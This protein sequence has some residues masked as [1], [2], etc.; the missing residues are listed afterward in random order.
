[1][2]QVFLGVPGRSVEGV[3]PSVVVQV[4]GQQPGHQ[5]L[6]LPWGLSSEATRNK[7]RQTPMNSRLVI[8]I[9]TT[10]YAYKKSPQ[11]TR[12]LGVKNVRAPPSLVS[13]QIGDVISAPLLFTHEREVVDKGQSSQYD[14]VINK[15]KYVYKCLT[16]LVYLI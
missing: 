3:F 9:K 12:V 14:H 16:L 6:H 8:L 1:M 13:S 4:E 5:L 7:L 10:L 2:S 15:K 11:K